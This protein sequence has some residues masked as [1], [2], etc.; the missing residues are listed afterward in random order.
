MNNIYLEGLYET[1][2]R[3]CGLLVDANKRYDGTMQ[4]FPLL[5]SDFEIVI[6]KL[7]SIFK[8]ASNSEF[9]FVLKV[10]LDSFDVLHDTHKG[11][12]VVPTK[13]KIDRNMLSEYQMGV[14]DQASNRRVY[15]SKLV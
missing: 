4:N 8:T 1:E 15:T 11:F 10:D 5:L 14:L 13:E 3:S 6:A 12:P 9:G 7:S 2:A